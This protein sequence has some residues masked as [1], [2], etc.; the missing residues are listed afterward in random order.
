MTCTHRW[1]ISMLKSAMFVLFIL[2]DY[3]LDCSTIYIAGLCTDLLLFGARWC[4][5]EPYM[6]GSV[7]CLRKS[8]LC[9]W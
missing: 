3:G 9:M 2:V 4:R 7:S 6:N 8:L 5:A 1:A